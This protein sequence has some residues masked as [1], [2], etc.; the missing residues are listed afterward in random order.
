MKAISHVLSLFSSEIYMKIRLTG[1]AIASCASC[2]K[3]LSLN[4]MCYT[5][6]GLDL[7]AF[8]IKECSRELHRSQY[9]PSVRITFGANQVTSI[10][11][12]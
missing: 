6:R 5:H 10:A 8:R 2:E 7:D 1:V 3:P 9:L 11:I 4:I 12:S